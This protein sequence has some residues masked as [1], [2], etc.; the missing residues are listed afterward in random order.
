MID[1]KTFLPDID[2]GNCEFVTSVYISTERF[3][4]L[5]TAERENVIFRNLIRGRLNEE[6]GSISS[7][8]VKLIAELLGIVKKEESEEKDNG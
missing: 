2:V 8:E 1:S 4:E 5:L 7:S 3:A 6:Y